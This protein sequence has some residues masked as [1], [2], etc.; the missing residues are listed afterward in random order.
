MQYYSSQCRLGM[1]KSLTAKA[2]SL[3]CDI[4]GLRCILHCHCT[5]SESR[6]CHA[7]ALS[8]KQV[9][10]LEQAEIIWVQDCCFIYDFILNPRKR[11][12]TMSSA[13]VPRVLVTGASGFL[14]CHIVKQ[15][16]EGGEFI[17]RGTVRNLT[18]EKKVEPLKKLCP[19]AK[20]DLELVQADLLDKDCWERLV[21]GLWFLGFDSDD[22]CNCYITI[23]FG[24]FGNHISFPKT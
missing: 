11:G 24:F 16:L 21:Y 3:Q 18:N 7:I 4:S 2:N 22:C 15:L 20:H 6:P 8:W 23:C 19:N 10:T 17:V 14:G 5:S 13:H 9:G 1:S 12:D